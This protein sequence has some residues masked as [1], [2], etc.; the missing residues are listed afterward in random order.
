[1]CEKDQQSRILLPGWIALHAIPRDPGRWAVGLPTW[2][3]A[4][5]GVQRSLACGQDPAAPGLA[6]LKR[7]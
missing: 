4:W 6:V 5:N 7:I 3:T 2:K 1:M